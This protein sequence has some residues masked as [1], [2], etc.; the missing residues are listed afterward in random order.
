[1]YANTNMVGT[2][3]VCPIY[4][5]NLGGTRSALVA[6]WLARQTLKPADQ[7]RFLGGHLLDIVFFFFFFSFIIMNYFLPV[8]QIDINDKKYIP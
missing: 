4:T 1:M 3:I 6:K 7:D 8:I 5:V 2:R